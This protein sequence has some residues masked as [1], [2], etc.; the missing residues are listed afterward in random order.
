MAVYGSLDISGHDGKAG[1]PSSVDFDHLGQIQSFFYQLK[2]PQWPASVLWPLDAQRIA[3]GAQI[4]RQQCGGC[5]QLSDRNDAKRE[6]KATLTPLADVGT[7]PTMVRNFLDAK[8]DT[9]AFAGRR[10]GVLFG[11]KFGT[12]AQTSD[13]IVHAAVGAALRHPMQTMRDAVT[14]YHKVIK[15]AIDAHPDYYKARPLSGI[16]ASAPYLHNGSVPSLAELLKPP[17]ERV[18]SFYVGSRELDPETVGLLTSKGERGSLF[19]TRLP[20]NSNAGHAFGT[21]LGA[22]DKLDLLEY[23]KSL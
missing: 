2:S 1:Y 22:A 15:A 4:Y 20:G 6:L 3:R 13:L 8:A 7:D 16:W 12:Q 21:H 17:G 10:E 19:D 9:G 5:H 14:G 11:A 18:A 23:L